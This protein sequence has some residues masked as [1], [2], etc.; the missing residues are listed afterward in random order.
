MNSFIKNRFFFKQIISA[1]VLSIAFPLSIF[2]WGTLTFPRPTKAFWILIIAY[3]QTMILLKCI[4]QF[5][6]KWWNKNHSFTKMLGTENFAF[7]DL[8]LLLTL[9]LHRAVLKM[10][11]LWRS[12]D[13]FEFNEGSYQI[14]SCDTKTSALINLQQHQKHSEEKSEN[15]LKYM[16]EYESQNILVDDEFPSKILFRHNIDKNSDGEGYIKSIIKDRYEL[17]KAE[18]IY[19]KNNRENFSIQL[20]QDDTNLKLFLIDVA[21]TSKIYSS[22]DLVIVEHTIEEPMNFFLPVLMASLKNY[23]V[24]I[25]RF[26]QDLLPPYHIPRKPVDVYTFMFFCDFINF[27]VLLFG[28]TEFAVSLNVFTYDL[29]CFYSRILYIDSANKG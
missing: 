16:N 14:I 24:L 9:F 21:N 8:I 12:D 20:K 1:N 17:I 27:L 15:K 22:D 13:D 23:S 19:S 29:Y 28:F 5:D 2:L 10:L 6:I 26:F 4:F 18:E 7:Y 25:T 11:G 3:T